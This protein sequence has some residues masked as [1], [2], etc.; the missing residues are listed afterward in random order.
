MAKH[1][2]RTCIDQYQFAIFH[3]DLT[4]TEPAYS[5][6]GKVIGGLPVLDAVV[7]AGTVKDAAGV[8]VKP[9][10]DVTVLD[11]K[12]SEEHDVPSPSPTAQ[13]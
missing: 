5:I 4:V 9:A 3:K 7:K 6:V 8:K 10:K 11:V 13:S 1:N 12:M 2:I